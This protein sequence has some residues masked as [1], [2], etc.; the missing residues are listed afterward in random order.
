MPRRHPSLFVRIALALVAVG[1]LTAFSYPLMQ[2]GYQRVGADAFTRAQQG[3][4][5][6]SITSYLKFNKNP[7]WTV[8]TP[9]RQILNDLATGWDRA[10]TGK[11]DS[12]LPE[13]TSVESLNRNYRIIYKSSSSFKVLAKS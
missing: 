13:A 11:R 5:E 3:L 1:L 10:M 12:F 6:Q 4:L 7:G 8:E 9:T 2:E